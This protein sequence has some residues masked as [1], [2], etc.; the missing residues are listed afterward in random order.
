M[1]IIIMFLLVSMNDS[2]KLKGF[3]LVEACVGALYLAD[4]HKG[5]AGRRC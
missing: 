1:H 2:V 3:V 5:T 4:E